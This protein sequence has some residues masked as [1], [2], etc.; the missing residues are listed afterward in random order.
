[1][2]TNLAPFNNLKARQ[3]VNWAV[4]RAAAV[5]ALRRH[6]TWPSR[7]AP[8]CRRASPVTSTSASTPRAVAR[9]GR[10][11]T[12]P[13]PSS[14]SRQ[15]GTAGQT[16]AIVTQND[17]VE[18]VDRRVPAE[19]AQPDRLQGH[20]RS[21]CRTNIQFTYIQNTN[22][23]VQI[24]LT[25]VVPGLPGGLGLP[26]R[27]AVVRVV[28]PGQRLEHQHLRASATRRIDAQMNKAL[29]TERT[30]TDAGQP[31]V[32]PDRPGGH[33]SR[34]RSAP[35]FTPKL[36]DFV[37]KRV[38]N[39][40]FSKQFYMLVD[41]LWVNS[42]RDRSDRRRARSD[43]RGVVTRPSPPTVGGAVAHG[44]RT[45]RPQPGRH[46]RAGVLVLIIGGVPAGAA[47]TRTTSRT[48]IRSRRT[49]AARTID[50]R[51]DGAACCS[52]APPGSGSA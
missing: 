44:A 3:A 39:Y 23:K 12:S 41:Q 15:S 37:S 33:D 45:A 10:R 4:D 5:R 1:M 35:L 22:N 46:G 8:S 2:N 40:Q 9:P 27:A 38:G 21:R 32:G 52:R 36:V 14:W 24:S 7:C 34:R 28:P 48:P 42:D 30:N 13:R 20:A 17:S 50:R 43:V 11:R 51:Q 26:A 49:S 31:A 6:R 16:V 29:M 25:P 18:Q 47:S 19:R